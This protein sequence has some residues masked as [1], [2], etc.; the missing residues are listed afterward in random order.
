MLTET[1]S[2]KPERTPRALLVANGDRSHVGAHLLAAAQG[3]RPVTLIDTRAA[4]EAPRFWARILH[5]LPGKRPA[6][7]GSFSQRVAA[8]GGGGQFTHVITTGIA[9]VT[10]RSLAQLR[11]R[12]LRTVNF[13]TDDPWNPAH[14]TAHF[15]SALSQYDV[16]FTPRTANLADLCA[17]GCRDVRYLPF[18]YN[19][20]E[21]FAEMAVN[22]EERAKYSCDVA[23]IGGADAQRVA[24]LRPLL[25]TQLSCQLYGGYWERHAATRR[26]ARGMVLERDY[27]LA[28]SGARVNICMGRLA[29]RD[30]HAMRSYE[31][32]AM[33]AALVVEDTGEHRDM[34]GP[35]EQSVLYYQNAGSLAAQVQRLCADE[36]LRLRLALAAKSRVG[37]AANTYAA[38]LQT[39]LEA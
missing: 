29:N 19:P 16:V 26:Y 10:A 24:L 18:A 7:L 25:A 37:T 22:D 11:A 39:L 15:W 2:S 3:K 31:L 17:Q 28:V 13:L 5:H 12:G 33:G 8:L 4:W 27:R 9:P 6:R 35:D 14:N 1:I 34:F 21:H 23:F 30:G 32:P 20:D 36:P 38:R